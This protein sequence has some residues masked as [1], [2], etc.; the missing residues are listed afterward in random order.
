M[1][2]SFTINENCGVPYVILG[3]TNVGDVPLCVDGT[4]GI[5]D[6]DKNI[7]YRLIKIYMTRI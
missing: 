2:T 3:F 4:A 5:Y 7:H 1:V 6:F